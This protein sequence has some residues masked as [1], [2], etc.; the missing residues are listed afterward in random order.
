MSPNTGKDKDMDDLVLYYSPW[1]PY[2]QKVIR[3]MESNDIQ[4][5]M[6]PTSDSDAKETLMQV[7]G[8]NQVPCL[9]IE[10]KP[11]YESDDIIEYLRS[12]I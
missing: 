2:C 10:G 9:F 8:K 11:L 5:E 6:R 4:I 7:G 1:C 12:R 3:F